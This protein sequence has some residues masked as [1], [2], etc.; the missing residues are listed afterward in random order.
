[1]RKSMISSSNTHGNVQFYRTPLQEPYT[2]RVA[3]GARVVARDVP[4]FD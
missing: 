4:N 1:M 3:S 2:L